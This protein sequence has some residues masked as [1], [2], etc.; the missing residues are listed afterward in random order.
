MGEKRKVIPGIFEKEQNKIDKVRN[1]RSGIPRASKAL[2]AVG[3]RIRIR[4]MTFS[5][6]RVEAFD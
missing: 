5:K 2:V 4:Q 1:N 3:D 6:I